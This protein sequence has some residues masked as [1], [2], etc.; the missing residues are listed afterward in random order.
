MWSGLNKTTK[1]F[2]SHWENLI[3]SNEK[4]FVKILTLNININRKH[5]IWCKVAFR[6]TQKCQKIF[7]VFFL[8]NS[9]LIKVIKSTKF[10]NCLKKIIFYEFFFILFDKSLKFTSNYNNIVLLL[11]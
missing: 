3:R 7:S 1:F 11:N 10:R 9:K 4:N 6:T 8:N 2:F 5:E